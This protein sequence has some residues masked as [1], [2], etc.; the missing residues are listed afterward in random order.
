VLTYAS[1]SVSGIILSCIGC[2][3]YITQPTGI[4]LL[5]VLL[6]FFLR[7]YDKTLTWKDR[8]RPL[9]L[10]L[11]GI[12]G[13]FGLSLAGFWNPR[14]LYFTILLLIPAAIG[15]CVSL[16][17]LFQ[18]QQ[19]DAALL[20]RRGFCIFLLIAGF[21]LCLH[22]KLMI[23]GFLCLPLALAVMKCKP[24]RISAFAAGAGRL[25]RF[26]LP[27]LCLVFCCV[28]GINLRTFMQWSAQYAQ[29]DRAV[30]A[31]IQEN[32]LYAAAEMNCN[33]EKTCGLIPN[34]SSRGKP[35][36]R[37]EWMA[38]Y[39]GADGQTIAEKYSDSYVPFL[40]YIQ[41]EQNS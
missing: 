17:R 38:E 23:F 31:L 33:P 15:S 2:L 10:F 6:V 22:A 11:T 4:L 19:D 18:K 5:P 39:Y 29:Y 41:A 9:E 16:Y 36:F 26:V 20:Y 21:L 8:L 1:A 32:E 24:E 27:A 30:L 12:S 13:V 34:E 14:P 28:L 25:R 3:H 40:E 37:T 35:W 7:G